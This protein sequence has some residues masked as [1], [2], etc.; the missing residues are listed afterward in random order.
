VNGRANPIPEP[1]GN[2]A[3]GPLGALERDLGGSERFRQR[4]K[5]L[6]WG[7]AVRALR[8]QAPISYP[9]KWGRRRERGGG[10][11]RPGNRDKGARASVGRRGGRTVGR[12]G[13]HSRGG[14]LQ[15]PGL[16]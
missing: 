11:R 1:R 10:P 7:N 3:G 8:F 15:R 6:T 4:R 2:R 9:V 5:S 14:T 16:R 12:Q 13:H